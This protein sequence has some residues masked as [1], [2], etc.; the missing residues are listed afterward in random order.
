[1]QILLLVNLIKCYNSSDF[2]ITM[3]HDQDIQKFCS[4]EGMFFTLFFQKSKFSPPYPQINFK[5][6]KNFLTQVIRVL[7]F[8][9]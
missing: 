4:P 1:M 3:F 2:T 9:L 6:N 7:S 8:V 5:N